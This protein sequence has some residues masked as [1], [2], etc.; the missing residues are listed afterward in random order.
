MRF[1]FF[2][3]LLVFPFHS[4]A[5]LDPSS[6]VLLGSSSAGQVSAG[7]QSGRYQQSAS[8][9]GKIEPAMKIAAKPKKKVE[10]TV[11]AAEPLPAN[12]SIPIA[13]I[14][15]KHRKLA[16]VPVLPDPPATP[17]PVTALAGPAVTSD[18][19]VTPEE[20]IPAI[21]SWSDQV[22][23]LWKGAPLAQVE[24][25]KDLLHPDDSR[26]NRVEIEA[27][28]GLLASEAKSN[29]AYRS[30][31]FISPT[32]F[33]GG[34]F[35]ITPFV[36]FEGRYTSSLTADV[37]SSTDSLGR[38]PITQDWAELHLHFRRYFGVSR[39]ANSLE[40]G[41]FYLSSDMKVPADDVSRVRLRTSGVGIEGKIRMPSAP[42]YTWIVGGSLMPRIG[43]SEVGSGLSLQSGSS[44][45]SSRFGVLVG[46]DFRLSRSNVLFWDLNLNYEKN[47]FGG[48]SNTNE[49]G[50]TAAATNVSVL[51][52]Q[53]FLHLGYRWGQ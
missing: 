49:P 46:G 7:L 15:P 30:F 17:G 10:R 12:D 27:G 31:S 35:W 14:Q 20:P 5:Q 28:S 9:V 13:V 52:T 23:S 38:V 18:P 21:P 24:S 4:H 48:T 34:A 39:K 53:T 11:Q 44:P 37:A 1:L 8:S 32:L 26:L 6:A 47:Q 16:A 51:T 42:S 25:Y 41:L 2:S 45:E 3:S 19:A 29:S 33:A 40:Y 50:S 36:G 43:H 22:A